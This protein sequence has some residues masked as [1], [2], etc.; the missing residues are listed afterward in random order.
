MSDAATLTSRARLIGV[1]ALGQIVSW[2]TGFDMLAILA[3]RIG[4]ELAIG[5]EIVFAG[6]TIMM[7]ISALCGPLLGRMLV[8]RGAAPCWW[9][10]PCCSLSVL[11]CL[12]FR[13]V[14]QA[15]FSAGP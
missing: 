5:N 14:S 11:P 15:I 10:V 8:R 2:G 7:L 3:P 9:P 6:L 12:P 1:L 13:A 4:G